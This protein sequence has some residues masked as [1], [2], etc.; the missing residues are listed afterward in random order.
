MV[1]FLLLRNNPT[2]NR[3]ILTSVIMPGYNVPLKNYLRS[4]FWN[5]WRELRCIRRALAIRKTNQKPRTNSSLQVETKGT[6]LR[7]HIPDGQSLEPF[8]PAFENLPKRFSKVRFGVFENL[9]VASHEVSQIN[10]L[11]AFDNIYDIW[12]SA[13]YFNIFRITDGNSL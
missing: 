1:C 11:H 9:L 5:P 7:A 10:T 4:S 13:E 12:R 2:T 3:H 8:Y 6:S